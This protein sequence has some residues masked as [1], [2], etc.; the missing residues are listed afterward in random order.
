MRRRNADRRAASMHFRRWGDLRLGALIIRRSEVRVLPAPRGDPQVSGVLAA[1][2]CE[3][4]T[5]VSRTGPASVMSRSRTQGIIEERARSSIVSIAANIGW[6]VKGL[7][8]AICGSV[9]P[10]F[11]LQWLYE[12][13]PRRTKGE[14]QTRRPSLHV[15]RSELDIRARDRLRAGIIERLVAVKPG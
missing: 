11:W 4:R 1:F 3:G 7:R 10:I 15:M 6:M 2:S 14:Y 13:I 12:F 9:T 8:P 5:H